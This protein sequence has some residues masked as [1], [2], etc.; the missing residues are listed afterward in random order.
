MK[1]C[2]NDGVFINRMQDLKYRK[3]KYDV[4]T[5]SKILVQWV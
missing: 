5:K 1:Y 3:N 4:S 2:M